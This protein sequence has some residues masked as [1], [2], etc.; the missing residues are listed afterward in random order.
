MSAPT[1]TVP[2]HRLT[3]GDVLT[4]GFTI[5]DV[6]THDGLGGLIAGYTLTGGAVTVELDYTWRRTWAPATPVTIYT[7]EPTR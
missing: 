2:A 4:D 3:V 6:L 5:T 7:E 1:R